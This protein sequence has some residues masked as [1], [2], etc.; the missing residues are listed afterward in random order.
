MWGKGPCWARVT[1]PGTVGRLAGG[2]WGPR[3]RSQHSGCSTVHSKME[4]STGG[5]LVGWG[6]GGK[7][8]PR[9]AAPWLGLPLGGT[10]P[11]QKGSGI[12]GPLGQQ[13]VLGW[14]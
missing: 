11:G 2:L 9:V 13:E 5:G 1:E 4:R 3:G 6:W 8:A 12:A 7:L 14:P 10:A